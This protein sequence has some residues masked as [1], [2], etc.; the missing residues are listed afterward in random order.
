[1]DIN[2]RLINDQLEFTIRNTVFTDEQDPEKKGIGLENIKKRLD[3]QYPG[4]YLLE[5]NNKDNEYSVK[6]II[7]DFNIFENA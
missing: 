4:R 2:L 1:V 7:T 5:I 3:L 6:L